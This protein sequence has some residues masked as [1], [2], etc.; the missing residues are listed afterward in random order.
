MSDKIVLSLDIGTSSLC[1]LALSCDSLQPLAIC[2]EVNDAETGNLPAGYHEQDPLRIL[3]LCF[4]L[5]QKL[6]SKKEVHENEVVGIGITGQMHGLLLVN[7]ELEP[8]SN[9]IMWRDQRTLESGN[10]GNIDEACATISFDRKFFH[11][12]LR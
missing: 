11:L 6:L 9:L 10:A 8:Q 5:I 12:V 4:G 2:S 3:D 7:S 1:G